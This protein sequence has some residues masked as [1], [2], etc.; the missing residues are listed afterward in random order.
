MGF[1]PSGANPIILNKTKCANIENNGGIMR[2]TQ[3]SDY[4]LRILSALATHD[5]VVD[6]KTLSSETAVTQK[7]TLKILHKLVLGE[8]VKSYKGIGGGYRLRVAAES[9][10]LKR[11]IELIDGPIAIARCVES[12]ECCALNQDKTACAFHHIFDTISLDVAKKLEAITIS[13]VLNKHYS[14]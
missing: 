5:N 8:L 3:E 1:S 13:D 7:F 2:I 9:I 11:V 14:I 12:S 6:A 4:A 10:T